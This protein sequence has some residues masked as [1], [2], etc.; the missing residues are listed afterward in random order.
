MKKNYSTLALALLAAVVIAAPA[1]AGV[2]LVVSSLG[3]PAP[4]L[5][6]WLVSA[7]GTEGEDVASIAN[8]NLTGAHQVWVNSVGAA[9]SPLFGDL[10]SNSFGNADWEPLDSQ[11][12]IDP[13]SHITSP[14]FGLDETN[15]LANPASLPPLVPTNPAFA[16][17]LGD[18][19]HGDTFFTGN[20][21]QVTLTPF[22]PAVDFL[23][24]VTASCAN[25]QVT[26]IGSSASEFIEFD[27]MIGPPNGLCVPE[28]TSI[29]LIGIGMV[30]LLGYRRRS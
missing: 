21:P 16:S 13:S 23:Q 22:V 4:G 10:T 5:D 27:M 17:F 3:S 1:R 9:K 19:G 14:G 6:S 12:L 30:G 8:L 28:P 20:A 24:V 29:A 18:A 15:D 7:V 25:L 2:D 11:L 26:M